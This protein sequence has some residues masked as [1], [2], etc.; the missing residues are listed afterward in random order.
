MQN[1]KIPL[2]QCVACR[3]LRDKR[4]L[5]RVVKNSEGRIFLDLTSKAAGRGAYVCDDPEC[6]KKLRKARL[7][8]RVFSCAV[9][10]GVYAAVEEQYFGKEQS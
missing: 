8:N 9:D 1:R 4:E 6:I 10:D 7:L 5:L 2:R 3:E